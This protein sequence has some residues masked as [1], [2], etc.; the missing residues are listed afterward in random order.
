MLFHNMGKRST[1]RN[2]RGANTL[3]LLTL[4]LKSRQALFGNTIRT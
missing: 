3:I 4:P 1:I 2:G